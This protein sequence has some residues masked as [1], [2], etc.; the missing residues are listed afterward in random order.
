MSEEIKNIKL[1]S[2]RI[3]FRNFAGKKGKFNAEGD[4]NFCVI[5][6]SDLVEDLLDEGWNLKRFKPRDDDDEPD[7]YLP[8]KI[9]YGRISPKI[10][11]VHGRKQTELTEDTVETLDYAEIENVDIV[12]RP[13]SWQMSDGKSGVTAYCKTMYVTIAEDEFANKYS[14]DEEELPWQP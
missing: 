13:Y 10:V 4:R 11:M 9:K 2:A 8:V 6:P 5:I 7:Y 14:D 3:V 12:I 1:E